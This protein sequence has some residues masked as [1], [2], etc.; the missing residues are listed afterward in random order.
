VP[1]LPGLYFIGMLFL[2]SFSSMLILGVGRD[3]ERV[4]KHLVSRA[5]K[6]KAAAALEGAAVT[7]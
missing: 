7:A 1:S 2:H 5:S 6:N 4:A 3:A